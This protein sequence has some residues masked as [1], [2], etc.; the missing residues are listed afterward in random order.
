M[1]QQI[2]IKKWLEGTLSEEE[3]GI[4]EGSKEY[5]SLEKLSKTTLAFKAP[6]YSTEEE[7][8][9]LH[10][11]KA[12]AAKGVMVNWIRPLLSMAAIFLL[13]S[14][15]GY[16]YF[17]NDTSNSEK[18][19][20]SIKE[21]IFLPDSSQVILN[22]HSELKYSNEGW[23]N[24]RQV[25]LTGEGFFKV[26]KGSKFEI[27]TESGTV[28]VLG[29]QFNVKMRRNYFEVTCYEGAVEVE[30]FQKKLILKPLQMFS[31]ING[32]T[33]EGEVSFQSSPSWIEGESTFVSTPVIHVIEEFERQ[34]K[35]SVDWKGLDNGQLFTG[36]FT[37]HDIE[38]ALKS[39]TMPLNLEFQLDGNHVIFKS[40]FT[41]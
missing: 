37:H 29:T 18:A 41:N 21:T 38:L 36:R 25:E 10:R 9:K 19:I 23:D 12:N 33:S 31:I 15:I 40:G 32:V 2:Y 22:T 13:V 4:F 14:G 7:L 8:A 5:K 16:F 20:S 39:I 24:R 30:T 34:Y 27:L 11:S 17:T 1:D 28:K 6:T 35:T 26:N 3:K